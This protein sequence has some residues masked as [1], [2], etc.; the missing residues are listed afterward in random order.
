MLH[1]A[2]HKETQ[3]K[4]KMSQSLSEEW[5]SKSNHVST[6]QQLLNYYGFA[7]TGVRQKS[8]IWSTM[9]KTVFNI[10]VQIARLWT[11]LDPEGDPEIMFLSIMSEQLL[12]KAVQNW[13]P[14]KH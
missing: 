11:Q 1:E 6:A 7:K 13:D 12:R 9:W 4:Q 8:H 5:P 3:K 2:E 14:K 10:L